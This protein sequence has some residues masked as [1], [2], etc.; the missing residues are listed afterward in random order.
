[1]TSSLGLL[2]IMR[3]SGFFATLLKQAFDLYST[4]QPGVKIAAALKNLAAEKSGG[5][6]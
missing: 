6:R 2:R 5:R 3:G 4:R 1:M